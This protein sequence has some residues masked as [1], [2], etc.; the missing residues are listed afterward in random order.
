MSSRKGSST[1]TRARK[2]SGSGKR[3][4]KGKKKPTARKPKPGRTE[5]GQFSTGNPGRPPGAISTEKR[6][7]AELCR[8]IY[9][10]HAADTF[11]EIFTR[12]NRFP[13]AASLTLRLEALKFLASR[14]YGKE[15][16]VVKLASD[17]D[18][19]IGILLQIA[20]ERGVGGDDE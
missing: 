12:S 15:P 11:R 16:K 17:E 8:S 7:L 10:E 13:S 6:E 14:G 19:A 2:D 4:S 1:S 5:S 3:A 9:H 18:S 20:R